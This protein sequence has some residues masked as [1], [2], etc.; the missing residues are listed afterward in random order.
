MM[1]ARSLAM[2][3]TIAA[4]LVTACDGPTDMT[5]VTLRVAIYPNTVAAGDTVQVVVA[6]RNATEEEV[7]LAF[8]N[9]CQLLYLI[10][11]ASGTPVAPPQP[12]FCT[13]GQTTM[14]LLP[15]EERESVFAWV[16]QVPAGAYRAYGVLGANRARQAG[17]APLTVQ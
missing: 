11:T 5:K 16:A 2:V 7:V 12:W 4:T 8:D 6:V 13:A 15:F 10:V 14:V 9:D 17:P 3:V 1:R